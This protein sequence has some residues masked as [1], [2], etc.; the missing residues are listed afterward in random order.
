MKG[1]VTKEAFEMKTSEAKLERLPSLRRNIE[2]NGKDIQSD[3][4]KSHQ[5]YSS[6]DGNNSRNAFGKK[7]K[8]SNIV[9]RTLPDWSW[10]KMR[11]ALTL[12][13]ACRAKVRE[14]S[15]GEAWCHCGKKQGGGIANDLIESWKNRQSGERE[16]GP[17]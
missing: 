12:H 2:S 15:R 7:N 5:R 1:A 13:P 3:P 11:P 10:F 16:R 4:S 8:K 9:L 6:L 14:H 17:P